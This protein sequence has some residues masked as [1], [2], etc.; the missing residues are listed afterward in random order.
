MTISLMLNLF[1]IHKTKAT[2]TIL[3]RTSLESKCVP[4]TK[5][6]QNIKS[7]VQNAS[8]CKTSIFIESSLLQIC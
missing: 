5:M 6:S 8:T 7:P 3:Q 2:F 1:T 4:E